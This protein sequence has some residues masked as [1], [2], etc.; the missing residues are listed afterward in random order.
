M[1]NYKFAMTSEWMANG[2]ISEFIV[3]H[4]DTDRLELVGC[5]FAGDLSSLIITQLVQLKDV[6]KGLIY[7]HDKAMIHGD[8]KGVR[9]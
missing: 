8:L 7:L 3:A 5:N 9:H 4:P 2:N 1:S 6:V